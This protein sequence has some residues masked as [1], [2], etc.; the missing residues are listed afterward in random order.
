MPRRTLSLI[1]LLASSVFAFPLVAQV[2]KSPTSIQTAMKSLQLLRGWEIQSSCEA[3]D[4][5]EKISQSGFVATGWHKTT[6]PNTVVGTLVDDKTYPDPTYATNLKSFPG[7][8]YSSATFFANQDMPDGSPFKCSW[9]WRNEF[10]L[11]AAYAKKNIAIHFPG[12]N[13]R[14]N[15]WFNGQKIADAQDVAGT[16]RIFEFDLTKYAKPGANNVIALEITAPA[17]EDLGIT[18]VD[19]NPTPADKDLGIWKEVS[20][21]ATGPVLIRNPF[22][23]SQLNDDFTA[24]DLTISADLRNDSTAA[25]KG[26]LAAEVDGKSLK[27]PV[28]LA[29]G[30]TK[31]VRFEPAQFSELK[32]AKPKLWWPY[33]VGTPYLYRANLQFFTGDEISDVASVSFGIRQVTSELTEKGHRLFKINGRKILIR[34]AAWA[35]DMFLRPMSKKLDADLR[36]AKDMGLNTIRLEGRIDRDELFNKTD[37][38]GILVMPGWTCCDA[39]ELWDRWTADSRKVAAASMS[40]Q[41]HRL[42]NHASVFVWLYGSDNPPPADVEKMYLTILHDAEWPNPSVSS[43]SATPTTITGNDRTLR[44]CAAGVLAGGYY[45]R[46]SVWL[47]H[48]D[49]SRAGNSYA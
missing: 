7:M 31:T 11:P 21:T 13:Y 29:A 18:W 20:V 24:A 37:E 1:V 26:V 10:V 32:F 39:W 42:R 49:Q 4:S 36:Y 14:A 43:A 25:V 27:L 33:T 40:D 9:W 19:W 46:R 41:A 28:E 48:R 15:V 47:Q 3:K 5:G 45:R 2:P 17:K 12:I 35:P 16:Y 23:K 22:V 44:I 8:N 30:E 34:G 38:L 6:V